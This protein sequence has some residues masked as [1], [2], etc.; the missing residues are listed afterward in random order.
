M[1]EPL[2]EMVRIALSGRHIHINP[3]HA[4]EGIDADQAAA[5]PVDGVHSCWH[6]LHHTVFWQDLMLEALRGKTVEWPETN[7]VS[8]PA[9]REKCDA[10]V[11][12]DLVGQFRDGVAEAETLAESVDAET[13]LPGWPKVTALGAFMIL[14]QHNA[15]HIGEIVAMRQVLGFWPPPGKSQT[16]F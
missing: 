1:Q 16:S 8:W 12:S 10:R 15:Y 2:L 14:A 11:W 5:V 6:L 13:A 3:V 7:S 4:L 9:P